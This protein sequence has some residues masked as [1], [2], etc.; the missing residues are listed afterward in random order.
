MKKL[1]LASVAFAAVS[2]YGAGQEASA[3]G[4]VFLTTAASLPSND[5]AT[6]V[7]TNTSAVTAPSTGTYT[8]S[9]SVLS[10]RH[11]NVTGTDSSHLTTGQTSDLFFG[12]Q[13]QTPLGT[14]VHFNFPTSQAILYGG[15]N[16][17]L[18]SLDISLSAPEEGI[19]FYVSPNFGTP[20]GSYYVTA[21]FFGNTALSI[22]TLLGTESEVGTV[23]A[24]CTIAGANCTF[25]GLDTASNPSILGITSVLLTVGSSVGGNQ[26]QPAISGVLLQDAVPEPA[27]LSVLGMGLLGL[28]ALRRRRKLDGQASNGWRWSPFGRWRIANLPSD[29]PER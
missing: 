10:T 21:E 13:N 29:R 24:A 11:V 5:T 15:G 17:T 8:T 28:G 1:A 12:K 27:S 3:A 9:T 16:G 23:E 4:P 2:I 7:S 19:G 14:E 25:I 20:S 26:Y 22:H 6:W 18:S